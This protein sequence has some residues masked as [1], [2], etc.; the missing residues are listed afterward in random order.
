MK[1]VLLPGAC[2]N[3]HLMHPHAFICKTS[4]EEC[5]FLHPESSRRFCAVFLFYFFFLTLFSCLFPTRVSLGL[6]EKRYSVGIA[7]FCL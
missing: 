4:G 3:R 1:I 5:S 7:L 2:F 6:Q